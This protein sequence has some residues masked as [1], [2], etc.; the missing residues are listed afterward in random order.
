MFF[1]RIDRVQI[2][3]TVTGGG[4]CFKR[5]DFCPLEWDQVEHYE[6]KSQV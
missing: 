5:F 1:Q 3:G 4:P 2:M 6:I